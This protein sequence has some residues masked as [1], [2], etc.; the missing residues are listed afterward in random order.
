MVK[1][2]N[3]GGPSISRLGDIDAA[4]ED[5]RWDDNSRALVLYEKETKYHSAMDSAN[6]NRTLCGILSFPRTVCT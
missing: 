5:G 4:L 1:N 6:R 2:E 3:R